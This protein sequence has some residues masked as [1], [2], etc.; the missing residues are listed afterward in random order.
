MSP[1]AMASHGQV[2]A[3]GWPNILRTLVRYCRSTFGTLSMRAYRTFHVAASKST[4]LRTR[5][6]FAQVVVHSTYRR[7]KVITVHVCKIPCP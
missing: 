3:T 5:R 6:A 2:M 4:L 1:K 7:S